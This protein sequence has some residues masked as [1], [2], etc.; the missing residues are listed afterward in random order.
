[1][2][3]RME[4]RTSPIPVYFFNHIW[5]WRQDNFLFSLTHDRHH[6]PRVRNSKLCTHN[7]GHSLLYRG[8]HLS[9]LAIDM[10]PSCLCDG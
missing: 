7:W 5:D 3:L 8:L 4:G 10:G 9:F 2:R 1:M 6:V